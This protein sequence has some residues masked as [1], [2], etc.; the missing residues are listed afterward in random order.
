MGSFLD[1]V[2]GVSSVTKTIRGFLTYINSTL[3]LSFHTSR[4]SRFQALSA[5]IARELEGL[6]R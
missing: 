1:V 4:S 6:V 5:V 3:G 2:W